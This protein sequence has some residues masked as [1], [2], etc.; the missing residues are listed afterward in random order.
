MAA[1]QLYDYQAEAFDRLRANLRAGVARQVLCLPT[2]GGKTHVAAALLA[3]ALEKGRRAVFLA[4]LQTLV[5]QASQRLTELGIRHGVAMGA[6]T[7]GRN[8]PIQVCSAQTVERRG[9][10]PNLDLLIVDEAH[11]M[12]RGTT[13]FMTATNIPTIGLT[14]TPFSRGMG[15]VYQTI[16]NVRTTDQLIA[17]GRLTPLKIWVGTPIDMTGAKVVAGEWSDAE[18]ES[19]ALPIVGDV[20]GDWARHVYREFGGPVRTAVFSGSVRHGEELIQAWA[21]IGYQFEQI[22]YRDRDREERRA[23]IRRLERNEIHGLVSVQALGRGF[24]VPEIMCVVDARP[25]RKSVIDVIQKQGRG[26]R[27]A[28][29]KT[30]ALLLDHARNFVRHAAAIESY[31]SAGWHSLDDGR[32]SPAGKR[33]PREDPTRECVGCGFIMPA[34]AEACPACGR[35]RPRP[36]PREEKVAG[37]MRQ[38]QR[39]VSALGDP[40][41]HICHLAIRRPATD[42]GG[43]MDLRWARAQ[44]FALTGDWP[45][46]G[47]G[48]EPGPICD[49]RIEDAVRHQLRIWAI[50]QKFGRRKRA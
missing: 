9:W 40:W 29:G 39:A 38:Y 16:V 21:E 1:V 7:H 32:K 41:P 34:A 43:K 4:D 26:M 19:R 20:V 45:A 12:R 35:E 11:I 46:W 50:K 2:G 33:K 24:D 6:H 48:L 47:R 44:F 3:G 8:E 28:P 5:D 13:D 37:V 14:A 15:K 17:D 42:G 27:A 31:W 30:H 25:N 49:Y 22:S 18:V 10:F 23:K 36:P